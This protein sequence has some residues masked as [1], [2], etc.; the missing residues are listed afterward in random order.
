MIPTSVLTNP[1]VVLRPFVRADITDD[2]IGW[3]NDPQVVR[4]SNQRFRQHDRATSLAYLQSFINTPNRFLSIVDRTTDH[5]VGTMTIYASPHHGTADVG[6]MIGAAVA[7]GKG[8]GLAAWTLLLD[9]LIAEPSLRKVTAGTL[10]CNLA[11]IRLAER[12]GM[13]LEGRRTAQEIVD[14]VPVD[15][16][17]FGRLRDA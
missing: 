2:Y 10:A 3:L 5:A 9:S 1:K 7:R 17:L 4:Y 16:L 14:G 8:L 12:S 6:I 13:I 15:I 11:M